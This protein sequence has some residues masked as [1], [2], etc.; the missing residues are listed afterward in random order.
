MDATFYSIAPVIA[1]GSLKPDSRR[2]RPEFQS[3][4][5]KRKPSDTFA[6]QF[7]VVYERGEESPPM[8]ATYRRP[9]RR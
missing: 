6:E 4:S 2:D 3:V 9:G 1:T 5:R 8:E 7:A